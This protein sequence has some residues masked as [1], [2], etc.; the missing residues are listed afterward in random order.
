MSSAK[1]SELGLGEL[2]RALRRQAD[3]SQRELAVRAGVP[4][5][6]VGRI[7]SG[8]SPNPSFR[9]VERLVTAAGAALT[10]VGGG[11]ATDAEAGAVAGSVSAERE[12]PAQPPGSIQHEELRDAADRH[13]PAHLDVEVTRPERWWGA[14]WT[15][16]MARA[17]WPLETVPPFTYDRNRSE[18]DRRRERAARGGLVRLHRVEV[19]QVGD[20]GW[21]WLAHVAD[22]SVAGPVGEPGSDRAA[23]PALGTT[24][25]AELRAHRDRNRDVV[26]DGVVVA[27]GWRGC[28]VGRRLIEALVA[29]ASGVRITTLADDVTTMGFLEACGFRTTGGGASRLVR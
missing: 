18:R 15:L 13:Y 11:T 3:L 4:S 21:M 20:G 5:A 28:G 22:G 7:E 16:T 24:R 8:R 19:P 10:V 9:T 17:S 6:T 27:P 14:W 2:L 25:V 26:L 1:P 12:G 23:W 29:E